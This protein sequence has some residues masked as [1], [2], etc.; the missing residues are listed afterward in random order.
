MASRTAT[1]KKGDI[2]R[3]WHLVDASGQTLGRVATRVATLLMGKHKA[4]WSPHIDTGDF[5]VVVNAS[6]VKV[7][8]KKLDDKVYRRHSGYLGNLRE[9]TLGSLL[10][11]RPEWLFEHVIKGMLPRNKI[12]AQ[13]LRKL[14]V[15]AGPQHPHAAQFPGAAKG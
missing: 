12:G 2:K 3:A 15:Y 8:G 6:K 10:A 5:V 4:T 9:E 7:T 13:M 14:K 11:R 1:V